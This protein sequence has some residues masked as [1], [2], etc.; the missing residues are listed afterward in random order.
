V[1][2]ITQLLNVLLVP[3]FKHAGLSLSIGLGA[4]INAAWLLVGLIRRKSYQ[5]TP[6]W[7]LFLLQVLAATAL[8]AIYLLWAANSFAWVA[9]QNSVWQRLGL[10]ALLLSGAFVLYL[11]AVWAAGLNLKQFLRR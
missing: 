9:L 4:L 5:P 2:V 10:M 8:L 11:G 1:L 3:Y 7:G 6:G